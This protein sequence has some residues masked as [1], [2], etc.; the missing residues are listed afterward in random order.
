M[1]RIKIYYDSQP[2]DVSDGFISILEHFG[3]KV[4]DI[5]PYEKEPFWIEYAIDNKEIPDNLGS[6]E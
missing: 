6:E 4:K 1:K 2:N 5:T 3:L